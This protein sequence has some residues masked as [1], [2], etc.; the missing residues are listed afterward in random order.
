MEVPLYLLL[1]TI[2]YK[3]LIINHCT[4]PYRFSNCVPYSS[5]SL[6]LIHCVCVENKV[7]CFRLFLTVSYMRTT[8][9]SGALR[10]LCTL[11]S[12][13]NAVWDT[14]SAT[15]RWATGKA[16]RPTAFIII[17]SSICYTS[18]KLLRATYSRRRRRRGRELPL[19]QII[20]LYRSC[21]ALSS[22]WECSRFFVK[23]ALSV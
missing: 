12:D 22:L 5:Y 20:T 15:T 9:N 11:Q 1:H 13:D 3:Y 21:I 8:N 2:N 23:C 4:C 6:N 16:D 14:S 10:F 19:N 7:F 17:Y 18:P